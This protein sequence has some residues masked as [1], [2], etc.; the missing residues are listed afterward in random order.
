MRDKMLAE[1]GDEIRSL[2][3]DGNPVVLLAKKLA[4]KFWAA[5]FSFDLRSDVILV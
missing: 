3:S 2:Y 5:G 4:D 1:A